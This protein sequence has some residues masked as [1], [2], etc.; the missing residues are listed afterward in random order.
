MPILYLEIFCF[1]KAHVSIYFAFPLTTPEC[2]SLVRAWILLD[3]SVQ[4]KKWNKG[5]REVRDFWSL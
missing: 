5:N 4:R 1:F 2:D 3:V